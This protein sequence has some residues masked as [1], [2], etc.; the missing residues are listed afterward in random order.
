MKAENLMK[1]DLMQNKITVAYQ[2]E[3]GAFS[4]I[5]TRQYFGESVQTLPCKSFYDTFATIKSG[6]AKYA[7]IPIENSIAGSIHENYD[8]LN[9]FGFKIIGEIY[10]R[11]EHNLLINKGSNIANIQTV[12]SHPKALEQCLD[13]LHLHPKMQA[14][15]YLDTAGSARSVCER[16]DPT[17]AAIASLEA[18][19]IYDLHVAITNIESNKQNYTR[20]L[21][22]ASRS[23]QIGTKFTIVFTLRHEVGSLAKAITLLAKNMINIT[24]IESRPILGKPWEYLFYLDGI[25]PTGLKLKILIS[26]LKKYCQTTNLLGQYLTN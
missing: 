6:I 25:K 21:V 7:V 20:F 1:K 16:K 10:L 17:E 23:V 11:I 19:K 9:K 5:A 2:G 4:D 12:Y 26:K 18:G 8:L 13:F 3:R 15:A 24:K 14:V 22:I